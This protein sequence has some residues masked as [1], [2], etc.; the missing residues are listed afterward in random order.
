MPPP[1]G[2]SIF[3]VNA[4]RSENGEVVGL[5]DPGLLLWKQFPK[6]HACLRP[7]SELKLAT[8]PR[9]WIEDHDVQVSV[10]RPSVSAVSTHTCLLTLFTPFCVSTTRLASRRKSQAFS[11]RAPFRFSV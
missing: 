11:R 3:H 8:D 7:N 4:N 5:Q 9:E 2:A 10:C 1:Q 6:L